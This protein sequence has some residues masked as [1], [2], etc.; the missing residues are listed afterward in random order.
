M[1]RKIL[2]CL[3]WA[4]FIIVALWAFMSF[5]DMDYTNI[6]NAEPA[7]WNLFEVVYIEGGAE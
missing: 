2:V 5:V 1:N 7:S 4:A 6:T 3:C